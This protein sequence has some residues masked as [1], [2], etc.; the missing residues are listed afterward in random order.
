MSHP[1]LLDELDQEILV[2]QGQLD[3]TSAS[4]RYDAMRLDML[5]LQRDMRDLQQENILDRNCLERADWKIQLLEQKTTLLETFLT[6]LCK[7][8]SKH[9]LATQ[10]AD[11][12]SEKWLAHAEKLQ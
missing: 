5:K 12:L 1:Q 2:A 4:Y 6:L 3:P 7:P 10:V 8:E 9:A 11:H